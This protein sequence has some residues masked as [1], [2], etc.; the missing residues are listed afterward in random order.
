[1]SVAR[2]WRYLIPVVFL[3]A[4]ARPV[5]SLPLCPWR[6]DAPATSLWQAGIEN[7]AEQTFL[8]AGLGSDVLRKL[9][10]GHWVVQAELDLHGHKSDEA[11]AALA[12]FVGQARQ[13]GV[14]CV[15]VIHGKGLSSPNR[16]PVLK[17]RV[18]RWLMH[19]DDVLAYCEA[20]PAAGGGGAVLV[21]LK[22]KAGP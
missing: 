9:R 14:R 1:M 8:R 3:A 10:R 7:E 11:H 4:L 21:L 5:G 19:R 22:A 20:P 6:A 16:E 15:K 2:S 13:A 17:G 12:A 18:R